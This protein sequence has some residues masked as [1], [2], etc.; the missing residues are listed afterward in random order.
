ME[1][2]SYEVVKREIGKTRK[3]IFSHRDDEKSAVEEAKELKGG[4]LGFDYAFGV[5][6]RI[7]RDATHNGYY[8]RVPKTKVLE[9]FD[10]SVTWPEKV[11]LSDC[12]WV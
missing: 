9:W 11:F 10:D 7:E 5:R 8:I 4:I 2:T 3:T 6:K 1:Y 12:S